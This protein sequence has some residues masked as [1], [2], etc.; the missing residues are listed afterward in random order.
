LGGVTAG[1]TLDVMEN[2]VSNII[3]QFAQTPSSIYVIEGFNT[4]VRYKAK[5]FQT[6]LKV[7]VTSAA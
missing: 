3:C 5:L 2:A 6:V 7:S 1:A 4:H